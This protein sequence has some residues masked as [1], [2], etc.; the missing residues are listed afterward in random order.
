MTSIQHGPLTVQPVSELYG[1]HTGEDI[2]IVGTGPSLRVFPLDFLKD[3]ITIGLNMAWKM[4][5]TTYAITIHPDL[6]IPE[7]QSPVVNKPNLQWILSI[8]P[9]KFPASHPN[10]LA[11]ENRCY[12]F[13][14]RGRPN[15]QPP[16][17]PSDSGRMIEWVRYP[18]ENN[19][20]V[21]SSISQPAMNLAA[22][23]GARNVI[24][25]GCDNASIGKNSHSHA[26]HTRWKGVRP[27]KRYYQYYEGAAEVRTALHE[28]GV[29]V[30]SMNPFVSLGHY[31]EDFIKLCR[32][33]GKQDEI[34]NSEVNVPMTRDLL[35]YYIKKIKGM[36]IG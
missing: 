33:H 16:Y 30:I 32:M 11:L 14:F 8:K 10:I 4:V 31:D 27:D 24:L 26:Q 17:E 9:E 12:F 29:N 35:V 13:D 1:R 20:Y 22:N 2:Y 23:M 34:V 6:N 18:S 3:K 7:L 15:T 5:D 25:I 36:V 21:W 19:L 28:R